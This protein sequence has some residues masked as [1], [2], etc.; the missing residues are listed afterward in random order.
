MNNKTLYVEH[1]A[2]G[3]RQSSIVI[4]NGVPAEARLTPKLA[5]QAARIATGHRDGVTVTDTEAGVAYRLYANSA[6]KL[7]GEQ[8]CEP[9]EE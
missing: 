2:D 9:E 5:A 1:G 3:N 4:L 6:R 7:A 8:W